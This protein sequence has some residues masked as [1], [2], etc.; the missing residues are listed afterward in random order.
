[1]VL[2]LSKK[3]QLFVGDSEIGDKVRLGI[4]RNNKKIVLLAD[5]VEADPAKIKK[6]LHNELLNQL[7]LSTSIKINIIIVF[8]LENGSDNCKSS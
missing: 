7:L 3:L 8:P 2:Y 6:A 4:I 1:M 5:I